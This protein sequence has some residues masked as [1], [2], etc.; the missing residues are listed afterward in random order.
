MFLSE[1]ELS[2]QVWFLNMIRVSDDNL[3]TFFRSGQVYHGIVFEQLT[4][5]SSRTDKEYSAFFNRLCEFISYDS[6]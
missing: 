1:Q 2:I 6:S 5:D 4:S 3:S